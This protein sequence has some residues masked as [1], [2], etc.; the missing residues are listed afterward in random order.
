MPYS[1]ARSGVAA[2]IVMGVSGSGKSTLAQAVAEALGWPVVEGDL[3]HSSA[4]RE[5]MHAGIALTDDH[6]ADWLIALGSELQ[7]HGDGVLL[8]CSALK[9]RYRQVL[10]AARPDVRFL[11]LD[12]DPALARQRVEARGADHFFNPALVASQFV[13]L[14]R[15]LDE[16]SV[17]R[18]DASQSIVALR[19]AAL[20]W[21]AADAAAAVP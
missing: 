16:P 10:R 14:E 5:R 11:F 2:I 6:R 17:L 15:P 18:L 3:F 9:R 19:D 13:A 20:A 7:R 21:I 1:A 8:T 4:N 12:V